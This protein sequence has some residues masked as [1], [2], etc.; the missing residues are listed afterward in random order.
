MPK[1]NWKREWW[2][3]G[4]SLLSLAHRFCAANYSRLNAFKRRFDHSDRTRAGS[5]SELLELSKSSLKMDALLDGICISDF[6]A[7]ELFPKH[8][9]ITK[10]HCE[11]N[12]MLRWCDSCLDKGLHLAIHQ[13]VWMHRCPIHNEPLNSVCRCG[14]TIPYTLVQRAPDSAALCKC[15]ELRFGRNP[16]V[17]AHERMRLRRE[18][19]RVS[20]LQLII[21]NG[22]DAAWLSYE[23]PRGD[24]FVEL[25][26][27]MANLLR[28]WLSDWPPGA[29]KPG[30]CC[31]HIPKVLGAV[32]DVVKK[33]FEEFYEFTNRVAT[34]PWFYETAAPVA[35]QIEY[36]VFSKGVNARLREYLTVNGDQRFDWG[37]RQIEIA[38]LILAKRLIEGLYRGVLPESGKYPDSVRALALCYGMP[39]FIMLW[40]DEA[41]SEGTAYWL[42]PTGYRGKSSV[43]WIEPLAE[44]M[45]LYLFL[46]PYHSHLFG[47]QYVRRSSPLLGEGSSSVNNT[48]SQGPQMELFGGV[49]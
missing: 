12:P 9:A 3:P 14:K 22:L 24:Q 29:E 36:R 28:A 33:R 37:S 7:R 32:D 2:V 18:L 46:E 30:I 21:R 38:K 23:T 44:F 42:K 31:T 47:Q 26:R 49:A 15:G 8:Y 11:I 10:S 5:P 40:H 20:H 1:F 41:K 4:M 6:R 39:L 25:E 27:L 35:D 45:T 13:M 19:S 34:D 43:H 48:T 17:S 16:Q